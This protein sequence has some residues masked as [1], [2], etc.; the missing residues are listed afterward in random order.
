MWNVMTLDG[1][2][3]GEK[4]WDLG[5]HELIWGE[6]LEKF[7]IEQM[8][9]ADTLLFG[10]VTYEGM[11]AYWSTAENENSEIARI[12]NSIP[13]VVISNTLESATWNNTR[14]VKGRAEEEVARLK[15]QPGKDILVFGSAELSDSLM[16]AGL[17]DEVRLC[18]APVVL[19]AGT[20]LFKSGVEQ[21]RMELAETRGLKT[22]GVMAFYRPKR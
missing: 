21:V 8:A 5:F 20:P 17:F 16:K 19:G 2:F 3:E 12:M 14:L 13:K 11:A 1:F 18:I 10:R 9:T 22:G 4:K 7:S 6:E 15:D